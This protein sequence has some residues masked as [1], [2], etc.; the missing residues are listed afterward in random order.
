MLDKITKGLSVIIPFLAV[1]PLW[2]KIFVAIWIMLS[3]VLLISLLLARPPI[4]EEKAESTTEYKIVVLDKD[5]HKITDD[6]DIKVL[7]NKIIDAEKGYMKI[8]VSKDYLNRGFDMPVT[9]SYEHGKYQPVSLTFTNHEKW[10]PGIIFLSP[11]HANRSEIYLNQ[12]IRFKN[13]GN[14]T[15]LQDLVF[16]LY[17]ND[18]C[19]YFVT[20]SGEVKLDRLPNHITYKGFTCT[21]YFNENNPKNKQASN[22]FPKLKAYFEKYR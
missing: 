11:E 20:N 10:G 13:L 22:D 5:K 17:F 19:I 3:A 14:M 2:V 7:E 6:E 1:Y 9:L 21:G 15:Y 12:C 8:R 18:Y 4:P 16:D